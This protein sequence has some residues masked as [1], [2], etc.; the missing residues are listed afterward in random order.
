MINVKK[1]YEVAL[2]GTN[3]A[4]IVQA[5]TVAEAKRMTMKTLRTRYPSKNIDADRDLVVRL[6]RVYKDEKLVGQW[7]KTKN[8]FEGRRG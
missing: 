3:Y 4:K 6:L 1:E 5:Q 2:R 8:M 7:K